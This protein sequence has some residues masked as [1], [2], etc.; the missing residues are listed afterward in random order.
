MNTPLA[1]LLLVLGCLGIPA[2]QVLIGIPAEGIHLTASPETPMLDVMGY[3]GGKS[4][5]GVYHRLINLM[6][7]HPVYC[8][9]FLGGGAVMKLKKPAAYNIGVD[10]D[11]EVIAAW[12]SGTAGNADSSGGI[13]GNG[14][15]AAAL[16]LP[17]PASHGGNGDGRGTRQKRR[18]ELATLEPPIVDPQSPEAPMPPGPRFR[19]LR[20]DALTFLASY[21]FTARDLIYL[22]P[23]YLMETRSSGRLYRHEFSDQQHAELLSTIGGL[24]C[25]VMISGYYSTMYA[26]ALKGWP[27]ISFEAMTRGG[28]ATEWLWWNFAPPVELHDYRYLGESFRERQDLKR[29]RNRWIARLERMPLLKKQALLSAIATIGGSGDGDVGGFE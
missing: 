10:L 15:S 21:P 25:R 26:N 4:G 22:D 16:E 6:P 11:A 17:I 8:E 27:S 2:E 19:F 23:P 24:P 3:P 13:G 28:M 29:Q 7:P 20:G 5:P 1:L 18:C 12:R 14:V 9:P